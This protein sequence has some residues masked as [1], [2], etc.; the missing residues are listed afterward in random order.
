M[1]AARLTVPDQCEN[2]R[3]WHDQMA[4]RPSARA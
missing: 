1:S 2:V 3:R 4:Q